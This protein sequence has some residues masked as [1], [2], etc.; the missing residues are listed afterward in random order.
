MSDNG[1]EVLTLSPEEEARYGVP[2]TEDAEYDFGGD[3][4]P[5]DATDATDVPT[6]PSANGDGKGKRKRKA[7]KRRPRPG[8]VLTEDGIPSVL[9]DEGRTDLANARRLVAIHGDDIRYCP[10][11]GWLVYDD[12]RWAVNDLQAEARAKDVSRYVW[13]QVAMFSDEAGKALSE[14]FR[15]C[16]GTASAPGQRNLLR[17]AQSERL[18]AITPDD[19]NR[20]PFALNCINGTVDL[21]TGEL[22]Q[23][24]REDL[25]TQLC[26]TPYIPTAEC[27]KFVEFLRKIMADNPDLIG[28]IQRA[29]GMSL[30]GAIRDHVLLVAYGTGQNGKSTLFNA[31]LDTVGSDYAMKAP[32]GLLMA[33]ANEQHPCERADL[34]G[35]RGV[36]CNEV[37]EGQRLSESL[38]KE[39]T[40]GDRI[41]ARFMRQDFFE[42]SPTHHLWLA[43]N[44]KPTIRGTDTGIWRRIRLAPFLVSI[45]EEEQDK[46]LPEKLQRERP[47]ILAWMVRGAMEWAEH[48][49]GEP[50][51]VR[52][53]TAA[54]RGEQDILATFLAER[55]EVNSLFQVKA[56]SLYGDYAKW[57]EHAGEY[58]LSQRR[59]G[60]AIGERGFEKHVSNGTWYRGIGLRDTTHE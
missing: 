30:S 11:W 3:S 32:L 18:I 28:F 27:P 58:V 37:D 22:R 35:K 12:T 40:G 56:S 6:E 57:A 43:V 41:R 29:L 59:F 52:M 9:L 13:R 5:I 10:Q 2:P 1:K 54:Y 24:R 17:L 23:H 33:K 16:R 45:P 51:E 44:H 8:S 39:L 50:D 34:Y 47:G 46:R 7:T 53:A 31:V 21:R 26:P 19:L 36:F 48:G 38:V 49:L 4:P 15:F 55:C 60:Q 25:L 42:F 20:D 14:I